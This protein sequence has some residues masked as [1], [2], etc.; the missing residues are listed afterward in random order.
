MMRLESRFRLSEET[1]E[2]GET[3][4][5]MSRS[6]NFPLKSLILWVKHWPWSKLSFLLEEPSPSPSMSTRS[7]LT[8][9]SFRAL[10]VTSAGGRRRRMKSCFCNMLLND[11]ALFISVPSALLFTASCSFLTCSLLFFDGRSHGGAA[12][13]PRR[14]DNLRGRYRHHGGSWNRSRRHGHGAFLHC[15]FW[16]L[17]GNGDSAVLVQ[18]PLHRA[19]YL[20]A[21]VEEE[22][23]EVM[24]TRQVL[25]Q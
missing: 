13:H 16:G 9:E 18:L 6:S 17:R 12:L 1:L 3:E 2:T 7:L 25:L 8:S 10:R 20:S 15:L 21:A 4:V 24:F 19:L 14:Y 11:E 22:E 23:E 5:M